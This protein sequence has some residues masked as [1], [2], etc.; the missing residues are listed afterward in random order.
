MRVLVVNAGSS[1]L[2]LSVLDTGDTVLAHA[3]I[4]VSRGRWEHD[5]LTETLADF[6][7]PDAV[8]HRVVHGGA[9]LTAPTPIDPEVLRHLRELAD[10]APLHQPTSLAGI[11]AITREHGEDPPHISDWNWPW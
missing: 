10:L 3:S 7:R 4:P 8:G 2:K 9:D 11:D 5:A 1:S 6:P